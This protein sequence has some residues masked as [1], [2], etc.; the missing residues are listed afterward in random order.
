MG[1][2]ADILG[3]P[4][5]YTFDGKEYK[6]SPWTFEIQAAFERYLEKQAYDAYEK[7]KR[8]LSQDEAASVL[9]GIIR[10]V[11]LGKYTF[12]TDEVSRALSSPIHVRYMFYLCLR[13]YDRSVTHELVK[14]IALADY[15]GMIAAMNL[16]NAGPNQRGPVEKETPAREPVPVE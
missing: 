5:L 2:T 10:D 11:A 15:A 8:Y 16:A 6:V 1:A 4:S 14:K 13:V 3:E 12:G 7:S 9:Q